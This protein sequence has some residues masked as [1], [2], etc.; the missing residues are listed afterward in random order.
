MKEIAIITH[1]RAGLVADISLALADG[2]VN[3]ESLQAEEVH[4]LA[5]V[6]LTVDKY[7]LALQ[8]LHNA[9]FQ[10]VTED[11][12]VVRIADEPGGLAKLAMR[13]KQADINL[14]SIRIMR[15]HKG[16]ALVA[17]ATDRTKEAM[18]LVRDCLVKK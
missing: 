4:D 12:I 5:V 3:I 13:F 11:A 8:T 15:R 18:D 7:D 6:H 16:T 14:R 1:S 2:G 17:L 9:G 10:A